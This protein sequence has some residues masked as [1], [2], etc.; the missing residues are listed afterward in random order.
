MSD[1]RREGEPQPPGHPSSHPTRPPILSTRP[2]STKVSPALGPQSIPR[3]GRR[4]PAA[5]A[6][7]DVRAAFLLLHV[8]GR[9]N[10]ATIADLAGLPFEETRRVFGFLASESLVLV[11]SPR[12]A[13]EGLTT[14]PPPGVVTPS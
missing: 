2:P 5:L 14:M 9:E 3:L 10:L 11:D 12:P 7:L 13:E 4:E 1:E 8:D 6:E